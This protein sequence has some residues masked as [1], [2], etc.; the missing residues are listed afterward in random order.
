MRYNVG[1]NRLK[2]CQCRGPDSGDLSSQWR[3]IGNRCVP[4]PEQST[5]KIE[6]KN[7]ANSG[8]VCPLGNPVNPAT[9]AKYLS[10]LDYQG[11]GGALGLRFERTYNS[12]IDAGGAQ[13]GIGYGWRHTY[14][15][16][17]VVDISDVLLRVRAV[18]P[19]GGTVEFRQQA[20][21]SFQTDP[22]VNDR[23][24]ALRDAGNA[25]TGYRLTRSEDE[26]SEVYNAAGQIQSLRNRAGWTQAFTWS[27]D[28]VQVGEEVIAPD[29]GYLLSVTDL[30]GRSLQL[31]YNESG[32]LRRMVDPAGG[33]YAY[34]YDDNENLVRVTNPRLEAKT[35]HYNE[36]S[37]IGVHADTGLPADLPHALTGI[38]DAATTRL[39]DYRYQADGRATETTHAGGYQRHALA[40]N[41]DGS[42]TVTDPINTQRTYQFAVTQGVAQ[43]QAQSV[44]CSTGSPHQSAQYDANGNPEFT[45]DFNNNRTRY[46]FD[47][48]RNLE[49]SRTEGLN[50]DDSPRPESRTISTRWHTTWRLPERIAQP[51]KLTTY[52]YDANGNL[53]VITERATLDATG[54]QGLN[55][56]LDTLEA[57]RVW[58]REH[59]AQGQVRTVNGPRT[60]VTDLTTFDYY[61]SADTQS[62]PR[63]RVGDLQRVTNALNQAT[64]FQE[65]DPH[66][67]VKRTLDPNGL[68]TTYEYDE[69]GRVR[70]QRA[71][72][73]LT[74]FTY[75]SRGLL[76]T[77]TAP[78]TS[79]ITYSYNDAHQLN[80]IQDNL[81]N[82]IDYTVID[83]LGNRRAEEVRDPEGVLRR[84]HQRQYNALNRLFQDIGATT[85]ATQ[86]TQYDYDLG[87]N[88]R[89]ITDP[90]GRVTNRTYDALNRLRDLIQPIPEAAQA[91][92]TTTYGY[93]G[94]DR[95]TSVRDPR[96]L[97]TTYTVNGLGDRKA[98]SSPDSGNAG[99]TYD[100]AGNLKTA[101]DARNQV[102]RYDYD[103]LNRVTNVQLHDNSAQ[104][105][106][107]DTGLNGIGRLSSITERD[108]SA[109]VQ[110]V[111]TFHYD[112]LGRVRR[113]VRTV[114]GRDFEIAYG[115]DSL[116]RLETLTYPSGRVLT[117]SYDPLG[118]VSGL[119]TAAV[120]QAAQPVVSGVQY[121]PFGGV[122]QFLYANGQTFRRGFD[123]DGRTDLYT[124]GARTFNVG[125]DRADQIETIRDQADAAQTNFYDYDG[126]GRIFTATLPSTSYGYRHDAVGNRTRVI[127][128]STVSYDYPTTNNRLTAVGG[129]SRGFDNNGSV[130]SMPAN[131]F[132]Y[133]VRGRMRT[134][135]GAA[136]TTNYQVDA[137]GL[138]IRKTNAQGDTV[139]VYDTAGR[140]LSENAP[141][142]VVLKEYIY[143]GDIPVAVVAQ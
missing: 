51:L 31:R 83:G 93:D 118:R 71:G 106:A 132:G 84:S 91:R 47:T 64:E 121:F 90:R 89:E 128:G 87:G 142:G 81:G 117:H 124:L 140:L 22:D 97:T 108:A 119:T 94:Q 62:P 126:L 13:V 122:S 114:G 96:L 110:T 52:D 21:G 36:P 86:I 120:S 7:T 88:L 105:Y 73:L 2:S 35:Y 133:D 24:V 129:V 85:P 123:R 44:P 111:L 46:V 139:F 130:T 8:S 107:Y 4:I 102:T 48:V 34:E 10:E 43:Q 41:P 95:V 33:E 70:E 99:N 100:A 17:L 15:R 16:S 29:A 58:T 28:R 32:S 1:G 59:N 30:N 74:R 3:Q 82:R 78:D 25:I 137:L 39:A 109:V 65:Y 11:G 54:A 56:A 92:P 50:P 19:D 138:R 40:Y 125:Y 14:S 136:G 61:T 45:T 112:T 20:D 68:V 141:N 115:Y 77:M 113:A 37:H 26:S 42:T 67:A 18:R 75:N 131:T 143:L 80:R 134:N 116:G 66:G 60:D 72:G 9:G 103:V 104:V 98:V 69:L 12:R 38:T 135:Q 101:T 79:V 127:M 57:P 23:L 76:E 63:W 27:T 5:Y 55:P 6:E 49:T 53:H